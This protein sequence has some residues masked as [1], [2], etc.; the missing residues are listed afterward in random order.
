VVIFN[1]L[2]S[3]LS[4]VCKLLNIFFN[5]TSACNNNYLLPYG[6]WKENQSIR[7]GERKKEK[8]IKDL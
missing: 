6:V 2:P 5:I 4:W 8:E 3:E 1:S 7:I